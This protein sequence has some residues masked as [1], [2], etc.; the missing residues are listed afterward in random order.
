MK[1]KWLIKLRLKQLKANDP[2]ERGFTDR[3]I[4]RKCDCIVGWVGGNLFNYH[5]C[6]NREES[7]LDLI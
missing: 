5:E 2:Y 4:I 1:T 6:V 7:L 3:K